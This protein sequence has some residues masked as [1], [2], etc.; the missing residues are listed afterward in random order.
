MAQKPTE[1]NTIVSLSA[2]KNQK[3]HVNE[4]RDIKKTVTLD[5]DKVLRAEVPRFAGNM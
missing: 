1:T 5:M 3:E 2:E 4:R